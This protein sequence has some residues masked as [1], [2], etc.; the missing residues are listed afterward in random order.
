VPLH[1]CAMSRTMCTRT[2]VRHAAPPRKGVPSIDRHDRIFHGKGI[3]LLRLGSSSGSL[4]WARDPEVMKLF[5]MPGSLSL[6]LMGYTWFGQASV[7][8]HSKWS[9]G[10]HAWCLPLCVVVATHTMLEPSVFLSSSLSLTA[11]ETNLECHFC[12]FL[13][14]SAYYLAAW[15][16]TL[17]SAALLL[18]G[19]ASLPPETGRGS[20]AS[21]LVMYWAVMLSS[22]LGCA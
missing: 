12:L 18:P 4:S 14:P 11:T 16:M 22:S 6:C 3:M 1:P 20:A 8:S 2:Q 7:R 9:I 19:F 10:G 17:D 13:L 21:L 15:R 5:I